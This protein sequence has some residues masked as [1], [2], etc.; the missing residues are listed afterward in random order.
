M[1]PNDL[2][3]GGVTTASGVEGTWLHKPRRKRNGDIT[4]ASGVQEQAT[5][6]GH[7]RHGGGSR[8]KNEPEV[9]AELLDWDLMSLFPWQKNNDFVRI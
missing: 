1:N 9:K 2:S 5:V 3:H 4:T 7:R 6:S 8:T